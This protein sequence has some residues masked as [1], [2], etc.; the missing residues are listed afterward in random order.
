MLPRRER[1]NQTVILVHRLV[2]IFATSTDA[3]SRR[4]FERLRLRFSSA[5]IDGTGNDADPA[6]L[7][8]A[9]EEEEHEKL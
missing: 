4:A 9:E 1:E 3:R 8:R 5:L 2:A 7:G 6:Q